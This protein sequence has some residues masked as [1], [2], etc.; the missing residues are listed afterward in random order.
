MSNDALSHK[1][2]S[3][4][5]EE[6]I[7]TDR[8]DSGQTARARVEIPPGWNLVSLAGHPGAVSFA[9]SVQTEPEPKLIGH[10][11]E[12]KDGTIVL[13]MFAR[14]GDE[15]QRPVSY[16]KDNP[17]Y[18][19]IASHLG[20][21]HPGEDKTIVPFGSDNAKD[22]KSNVIGTA[23]INE[24]GTITVTT[25]PSRVDH[26]AGET[27]LYPPSHRYYKTVLNHLPGIKPGKSQDLIAWHD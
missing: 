26:F 25:N 12:S 15:W 3:P 13:H 22:A 27:L 21:I 7:M 18:N 9:E 1:Q 11:T 6:K 4:I 19:R 2:D 16:D 24:V 23:R 14:E 10:A 17:V 5:S 20:G 8:C